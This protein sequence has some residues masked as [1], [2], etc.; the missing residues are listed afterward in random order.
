MVHAA[1][2]CRPASPRAR[3]QTPVDPTVAWVV[4]DAR[5]PGIPGP[6]TF[7]EDVGVWAGL[8]HGWCAC[9]AAGRVRAAA[10]TLRRPARF[11][12]TKDL[13]NCWAV[14][15]TGGDR[16]EPLALIREWA[17]KLR[18]KTGE[19]HVQL[20]PAT[21]AGNRDR[22]RGPGAC[23]PSATPGQVLIVNLGIGQPNLQRRDTSWRPPSR[24]CGTAT[25]ATR[26]PRHRP[27]A[28]GRLRDLK[29]RH[30]VEVHP[31]TIVIWP[32]GKP[33][34]CFSILIFGQPGEILYPD[35]GFPIYRSM[36]EFTGARPVPIVQ[37]QAD[38]SASPPTRCCR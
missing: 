28:R 18:P 30:G 5:P 24:R 16:T 26:P 13:T 20:V 31:D 12:R 27:A 32:G 3:T 36:I 17:L 35:P 25:T 8:Y 37:N 22:L 33:T 14:P 15:H 21:N 11:G 2:R 7:T 38:S 23:R 34:M 10:R 6:A 9:R 4:D 1:D 19:P 29:R